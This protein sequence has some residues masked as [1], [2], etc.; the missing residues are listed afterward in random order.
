VNPDG[1]EPWVEFDCNPWTPA[2]AEKALRWVLRALHD[3]QGRLADYRDAE[4]DAKHIWE[5]KKREAFASPDCPIPS[6]TTGVTTADR[7]AFIE[8]ES[9]V[10]RQ[11]YEIAQKFT[12]GSQEH[13]RTLRDQSV[14]I[15]AL[16]KT[17]GQ[18][19][20]GGVR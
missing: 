12:Q 3:E 7:E 6:R 14:V 19:V 16:A 1:S 9:W 4:L 2:D 8:R 15:S 13:L 5:A 20:G 10:E 11:E 18:V 17:V